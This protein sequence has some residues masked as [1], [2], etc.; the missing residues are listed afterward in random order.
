LKIRV[1]AFLKGFFIVFSPHILSWAEKN[2]ESKMNLLL[3]NK[4]GKAGVLL[5]TILVIFSTF[6]VVANTIE[7]SYI[8]TVEDS[9][10]DPGT[11]DHLIEVT[12]VW[13]EEIFSYAIYIEYG[14]TVAP[15]DITVTDVTLDGC[16]GEDPL[17]FSPSIVNDGTMGTIQVVVFYTM[18]MTPG[19]GIPAGSGTL[20]NIYLDVAAGCADQLVSFHADPLYESHY[21][22]NGS[23]IYVDVNEGFLQ[24][25]E[26]PT[27]I[28]TIEDSISY[29]GAI[30]H[31]IEVT[32]EWDQEIF[33]FSLDVDYGPT[34]GVGAIMMT[35]ITL[36]D[37]I[38]ENPALLIT[39]LDDYGDHG[40]VRVIV[41]LTDDPVP[42]EGIPPGSGKL[43]NMI[44]NINSSAPVQ[45]VQFYANTS[46]V[47]QY[48]ALP[49]HLIATVVPGQLEI[50]D[51]QPPATPDQPD[52]ETQGT[53]GQEY[54]Y[55]TNEVVDPDGDD[56][57]Y[58]FDWGNGEDS[59]WLSVPNACYTW[60]AEGTYEVKVK[61]R[62][63]I[64]AESDW[65]EPLL[66]TISSDDVHLAIES[67]TGGLGVFVNITND[68]DAAA[69][70]IEWS[71]TVQGGLLGLV[72]KTVTD[73]IANLAAGE[74]ITLETG[75]I[76]LFHLGPITIDISVESTE[77]AT[78]N[79]SKSG[80][81]IAFI[82]LVL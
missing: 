48:Y 28:M 30:D 78:L 40:H 19:T 59:G 21:S 53:V 79:E 3:K 81:Q 67:I 43:F 37:C 13:E 42:D 5:L 44:A 47:S 16:V 63:T 54:C 2:G 73:S 57:E 38:L 11:T 71:I 61:A 55:S 70:S 7:R 24:I 80:F 22:I 68:G 8:I 15:G 77:G 9:Q 31:V 27:N 74:S 49:E 6:S 62:D 52:G 4:H 51:N 69:T 36:E 82:T 64:G 41:C 18:P 66:V 14:P 17:I 50:L 1:E 35:D 32:G 12:G 46:F 10:A 33:G 20:V 39:A 26:I 60:S 23:Q 29:P 34:Q 56:V 25:G 45:T 72:N 75:I 76:G 58:L 65:S